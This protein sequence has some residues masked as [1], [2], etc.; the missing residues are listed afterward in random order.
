MFTPESLFS[1][2]VKDLTEKTSP[3]SVN[4]WA[5]RSEERRVGKGF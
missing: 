5:P 2:I 3:I 1:E 4:A